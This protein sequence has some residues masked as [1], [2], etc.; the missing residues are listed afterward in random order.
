MSTALPAAASKKVTAPTAPRSVKA[1]AGNASATVSW[2]APK[3]T[4]GA[5]I[6][7][8]T[9]TSSPGA[10]TCTTSALKCTVSGLTNGTAYSFTVKAKNSKGTSPASAASSKVTPKGAV[11]PTTAAGSGGEAFSG[12]FS[13]KIGLLMEGTSGNT[14]STVK[15]T[16]FTGS[17]TSVMGATTVSAYSVADQSAGSQ[18]DSGLA[19]ATGTLT[20]S[21]GSISIKITSGTA[22]AADS[23]TPT[24]VSLDATAT[25]TSGTGSFAGAS[26]TLTIK[27]SFPVQSNNVTGSAESDSYSATITGTIKP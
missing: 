5:A 12:T 23:S 7:S 24:T 27:G 20:S 16:S 22:T 9:V 6:K 26:G 14:A 2:L 11:T 25:I 3:S 1:V 18:T 17:G 19:G 10:K 21:S 4:G 8:Y 13:G 15:V